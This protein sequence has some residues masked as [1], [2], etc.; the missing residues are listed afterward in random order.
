MEFEYNKDKSKINLEKH[1]ID[2]EK[3]KKLWDNKSAIIVPA[4]ITK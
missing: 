2:F 4:K 3:S 1:G